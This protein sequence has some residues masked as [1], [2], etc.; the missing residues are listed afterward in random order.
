MYPGRVPADARPRTATTKLRV[1]TLNV[2]ALPWPVG[3]GVLPR[4]RAIAASL[5][6]I[7]AD[8]VLFQ[9]VWRDDARDALL[10]AGERHGYAQRWQPPGSAGGGSGLLVLS[11]LPIAG[12][13]FERY[14]LRGLPERVDHGDYHGHKGFVVL[15]VE[16]AAGRV[17]V[18]NTH[19]HAQYAPDDR[20]E[21]LA[22]RTGQVVQLASRLAAIEEPVVAAGDFNVREGRPEYEVLIGLTGLRDAAARLDAR[23]NTSRRSNPYHAGRP[24][25]DSRID[26]VFTRDGRTLGVQPRAVRR[27]WDGPVA[28]AHARPADDAPAAYSDHDGLVADLA[29]GPPAAADAARPPAGASTGRAQAVALARRILA[30]GRQEA[31]QRRREQRWTGLAGVA[32]GLSGL[33]AAR[34]LRTGRRRL[35]RAAFGLSPILLLPVGGGLVWLSE[36]SV[37]AE[38]DAYDRVEAMLVPLTPPA[39]E[40][41]FR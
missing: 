4:M 5:P 31:L 29:L 20:D 21:Y 10:A 24:G 13:H 14:A 18:L 28:A 9:E 6:G 34:A 36:G 35:L 15:H 19:L 25:P 7:G 12:T 30:Q 41:G 26:Y 27:A 2:W 39:P 38:L 8:V 3:R 1:A 17:A 11:R 23:R 16:T 37:A 33:A 40:P 32:A 22:I